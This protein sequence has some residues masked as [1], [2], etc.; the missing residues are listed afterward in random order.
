MSDSKYDLLVIG[1]EPG[2]LWLLG[3]LHQSLPATRLAHLKSDALARA[4]VAVD[5]RVAQEYSLPLENPWS[6]EIATPSGNFLWER[7]TLLKNF[8]RLDPELFNNPTLKGLGVALTR[9]PELLGL[10]QG[11]W[12]RFSRV[13][14]LTPETY[15]KALLQDR[16]TWWQPRLPE[17]ISQATIAGPESITEIDFLERGEFSVTFDGQTWDTKHIVVAL[18]FPEI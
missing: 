1:S 17:A 8:T 6:V 18:S 5:A 4:P 11:L 2:A 14:T 3:Q 7:E 9:H 13:Q 15:L 12:K 10:C 16:F